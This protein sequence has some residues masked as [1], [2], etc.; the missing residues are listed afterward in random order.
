[1]NLSEADYEIYTEMCSLGEHRTKLRVAVVRAAHA[2]IR[3][4]SHHGVGA[5]LVRKNIAVGS[6]D[7]HAYRVTIPLFSGHL[8]EAS[9]KIAH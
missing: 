9:Q 6:D 8:L 4:A 7:C 5:D 2:T 1:M 3:S